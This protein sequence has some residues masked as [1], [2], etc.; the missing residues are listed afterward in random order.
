MAGVITRTVLDARVHGVVVVTRTELV[1]RLQLPDDSRV[2]LA[3][4]D[5]TDSEMIDSIRLGL[6]R[7]EELGAA[8]HDGVLEVP[9]DMPTLTAETCQTCMD[10]Y[11]THPQRIVI[12]TY[13]GRRGHPII[14]PFS[15]RSTIDELDGGLRMLPQRLPE[16][17]IP[18]AVDDAGTRRDI[19]TARDYD[20]LS[21][22]G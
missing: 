6:A 21:G 20:E 14:F 13:Q 11:R 12:A 2:H 15:L 4:N 3:I 19:D 17:V 10:V 7:L 9:A 22:E 8:S 18:V 5:D 16:R 1:D